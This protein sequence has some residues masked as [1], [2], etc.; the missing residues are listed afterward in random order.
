MKINIRGREH[1]RPVEEGEIEVRCKHYG[2]ITNGSCLGTIFN[3]S[4]GFLTS[5]EWSAITWSKYLINASNLVIYEKGA[6]ND[7]C[8][9]QRW[10]KKT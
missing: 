4:C 5:C 9:R 7:F 3:F 8:N 6:A 2:K 10:G 1:I